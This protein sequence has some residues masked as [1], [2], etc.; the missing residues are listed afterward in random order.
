MDHIQLFNSYIFCCGQQRSSRFLF[1]LRGIR[2]GDSLSRFSSFWPWR[3]S[4]AFWK[5][6]NNCNRLDCGVTFLV[7]H[8]LFADDTLISCGAEESQVRYL[9]DSTSPFLSL[10]PYLG[11]TFTCRVALYTLSIWSLN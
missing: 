10:K 11:S 6:Q 7:S 8:L 9:N 4:V 2:Q 1:P 3:V 5:R